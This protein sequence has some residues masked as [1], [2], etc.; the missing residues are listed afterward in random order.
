[1]DLHVADE[2]R[3]QLHGSAPGEATVGRLGDVERP[4]ADVEVVP[5]HVLV[6]V[7]R[8]GRV[9]ADPARLAVVVV[10]RVHTGSHRPGDAVGREPGAEPEASAAGGDEDRDP[11]RVLDV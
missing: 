3:V 7:V 2:A 1:R 4:A 10:A 8:A 5:A 11:L 6:A 9:V